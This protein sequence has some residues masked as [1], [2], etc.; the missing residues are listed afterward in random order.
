MGPHPTGLTSTAT[1]LTPRDSIP[2]PQGS[3]L[4]PTRSG[5]IKG[6]RTTVSAGRSILPTPNSVRR[7]P[8]CGSEPAQGDSNPACARLGRSPGCECGLEPAP[9]RQ[10]SRR[11]GRRVGRPRPSVLAPPLV[12]PRDHGLGGVPPGLGSCCIARCRAEGRTLAVL[13]S[14]LAVLATFFLSSL[15]HLSSLPAR[16]MH[17]CYYRPRL[18]FPRL[19]PKPCA[20]LAHLTP[21]VQT[22]HCDHALFS[23]N[24]GVRC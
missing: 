2:S 13:R 22:P 24:S 4:L 16:T 14:S 11:A 15:C 20:C 12:I 1:G 7:G 10:E 23:H 9:R 17:V 19:S 18:L 21:R 8:L 6:G 5:H 3:R